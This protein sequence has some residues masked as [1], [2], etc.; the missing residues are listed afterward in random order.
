M[1]TLHI[2][3]LAAFLVCGILAPAVK[4]QDVVIEARLFK[5]SRQAQVGGSDVVVSSFVDPLL[6]SK[7]PA[8]IRTEQG[9]IAA[10]RAELFDIYHLLSVNHIT[11]SRFIWD[12]EKRSLGG[13]ITLLDRN[14]PIALYPKQVSQQG[15]RL[16]VAVNRLQEHESLGQDPGPPEQIRPGRTPERRVVEGGGQVLLNTEI[17][18][19]YN[20]PVVLGFPENGHVY[21]LSISV[22]QRKV[23]PGSE[24]VVPGSFSGEG[25]LPPPLPLREVMPEYPAG[26]REAQVEGTVIL[27]LSIDTQGRVAKVTTLIS[28][29]PDLERTAHAAL[30]RWHY[31]PVLK[32]GRP[33]P[34]VFAV[35]VEFRLRKGPANTRTSAPDKKDRKSPTP[36]AGAGA[37]SR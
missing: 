23:D 29:H 16:R 31:E 35:A 32:R 20:W 28:T 37:Q 19:K 3:S 2:F 33:I 36:A 6:V 27:N 30:Q 15:L 4:A 25:Y 8:R 22:S 21:F 24:H 26:L 7:D 11:T 1:R 34:A 14:Y 18:L 12:G 5:G 10:M 9:Q 13:T 17:D